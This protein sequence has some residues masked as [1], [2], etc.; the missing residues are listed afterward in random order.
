MKINLAHV[1]ERS[2]TGGSIDF[3]VFGAKSSS[4]SDSGNDILLSQ[5]TDKARASGLKIDQSALAYDKNGVTRFYGPK[6]LVDY[7]S[8][9]GLPKWTHEIDV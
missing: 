3:A 5:L 4:E 1:R 6:G 8:S 2:T 7:L 9:H